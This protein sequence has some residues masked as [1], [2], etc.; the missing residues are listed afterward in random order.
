ML[1]LRPQS[2]RSRMTSSRLREKLDRDALRRELRRK[3]IVTRLRAGHHRLA[4]LVEERGEKKKVIVLDLETAAAFADAAL[5]QDDDL[6]AAPERIHDHRP[7]LER[8]PHGRNLG[9][10]PAGAQLAGSG[11]GKLV[12]ADGPARS[13]NTA[14]IYKGR[15]KRSPCLVEIHSG[16]R[17]RSTAHCEKSQPT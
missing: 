4:L 5:A 17:K 1:L 15:R 6:V 7:F 12:P 16:R 10:R 13:D 14:G 11:D 2:K 8:H 9:E 3:R